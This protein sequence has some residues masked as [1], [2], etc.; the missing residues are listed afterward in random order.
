MK[1]VHFAKKKGKKV[2]EKRLARKIRLK[3]LLVIPY[4]F[5]PQQ[6]F[7]CVPACIQMILATNTIRIPSQE[8]IAKHLDFRIPKKHRR[9]F[10]GDY[11]VKEKPKRGY[12]VQQTE[13][14]INAFLSKNGF[15]LKAKRHLISGIKNPEKFIEENLRKGNYLMPIF[16]LE[17]LG[18]K[19]EGHAVLIIS[20]N[21][22]TKKVRIADPAKKKN[23]I[24]LLDLSRIVEGMSSKWDGN[25]REFY[26]FSRK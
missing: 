21:P 13:E 14:N 3:T 19:K 18:G 11:T 26:V 8:F 7:C 23:R 22:K 24:R 20:F 17:V 2:K 1:S 25:E 9:D 5:H 16:N 12:G 15:P 6:P 4:L 10:K